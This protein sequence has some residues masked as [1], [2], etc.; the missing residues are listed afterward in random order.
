VDGVS[1]MRVVDRIYRRLKHGHGH[2]LMGGADGGTEEGEH[3]LG[4]SSSWDQLQTMKHRGTKCS[5][6]TRFFAMAV[7]MAACSAAVEG[8]S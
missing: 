1:H 4:V 7:R 6:S 5:G 2:V 3:M 8:E